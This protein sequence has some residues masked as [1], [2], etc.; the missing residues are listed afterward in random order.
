MPRP[1]VLMLIE[2]ALAVLPDAA[3]DHGTRLQ[4]GLAI[5]NA[6]GG[7]ARG[8][9]I[10][11][12]WCQN[13]ADYDPD[14][15]GRAWARFDGGPAAIFRLADA[16]APDWR[17]PDAASGVD[18]PAPSWAERFVSER[19]AAVRAAVAKSDGDAR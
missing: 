1:D 16:T 6:C 10:W 18:R 3:A 19:L 14:A 4:F 5:H 13:S 9:E 2:R 15:S 12:R 7:S 17:Y 11:D 8:F